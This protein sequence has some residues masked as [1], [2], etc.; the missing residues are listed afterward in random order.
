MA[1]IRLKR[2]SGIALSDP[3]AHPFV[4]PYTEVPRRTLT[5]PAAET[6]VGGGIRPTAL[7][8]SCMLEAG[9]V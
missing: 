1:G 4:D 2:Q 9:G 7:F 3:L 6:C 5:M 8:A